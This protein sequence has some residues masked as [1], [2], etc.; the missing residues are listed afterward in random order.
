M[1]CH[2]TF[3]LHRAA[4]VNITLEDVVLN[5]SCQSFPQHNSVTYERGIG[6]FDI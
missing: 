2:N 3:K 6:L 1:C 4:T 5:A